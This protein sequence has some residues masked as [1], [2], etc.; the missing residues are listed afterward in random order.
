MAPLKKKYRLASQIGISFFLSFVFAFLAAQVI[1][2][3]GIEIGQGFDFATVALLIGLAILAGLLFVQLI[4][5]R[6]LEMIAQNLS[7][8]KTRQKLPPFAAKEL[9]ELEKAISERVDIK[10]AALSAETE[11]TTSKIQ[12]SGIIDSALDAVVL[13]NS[14]G[15]VTEWNKQAETLF[16]W[17]KEEALGEEMS[18]MIIPKKMRKMHHDGIDHYHATKEGPVINTR[19]EVPAIN[20]EGEEFPVE[21][22]VSPFE[23]NEE[24]YFSAFVRDLREQKKAEEELATQQERLSVTLKSMAEGVILTDSDGRVVLINPA[25]LRLLRLEEEEIEGEEFSKYVSDKEFLKEWKRALKTEEQL[26]NLDF[27]LDEKENQILAATTSKVKLSGSEVLGLITIIRDATE[28]KEIDRMKSDFVSSVSHELRTPLT[29]IKGFTATMLSKLKK[30]DSLDVETQK[31][32]LGIIEEETVRLESLI[33]DILE[34]SVLETGKVSLKLENVNIQEI[35]DK[36]SSIAKPQ[37]EKNKV[38]FEIKKS[39]PLQIKADAQKL[40]TAIL[41]LVTN[42]IKFTEEGGE[43]KVEL[44]KLVD[45]LKIK[46]ID[47]GL[48]VPKRDLD[49]I[50]NR[51][52][53]VSR[54][55]TE[56]QGTGLGLAIVKEIAELHGGELRVE[57]QVG[58]GSTFIIELPV[59]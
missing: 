43:V 6:P 21:L 9:V 59:C 34:I 55:G 7:N 12:M 17:S 52:F 36:V 40:Q 44:E 54:P 23:I 47:T 11:A 30:G 38:S 14:L 16:G 8:P 18:D 5:V 39:E 32:F 42:A 25:G 48:G 19:V 56:I 49:N 2:S 28:E 26:R 53:R 45:K 31:E 50:F 1:S 13:I 35:L 51:F 46:I 3:L 58:E 29:S 4:A 37:A 27:V 33:R 20:R 15:K 24:T 22:T 57:S 10:N 41:N